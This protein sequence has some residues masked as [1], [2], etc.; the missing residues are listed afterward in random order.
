[1]RKDEALRII[2]NTLK[3]RF[4]KE[5]FKEL[6]SN[7]FTNLNFKKERTIYS[8]DIGKTFSDGI[9]SYRC[10]SR[11]LSH[12]VKNLFEYRFCKSSFKSFAG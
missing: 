3:N 12:L 4:N 9:K 10:L 2:N 1:M 8:Q 11:K 6:T 5:K 7:L